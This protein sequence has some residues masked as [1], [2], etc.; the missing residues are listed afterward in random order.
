MH[1]T[2]KTAPPSSAL[3]RQRVAW[4][5]WVL[6]VLS[7]VG[8][9]FAVG[10]W[11]IGEYGYGLT[12]FLIVLG[13]AVMTRKLIQRV[14]DDLHGHFADQ[15]QSAQAGLIIALILAFFALPLIL[16]IWWYLFDRK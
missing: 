10:F 16:S 6:V 5:A 13:L 14:P 7:V 15:S 3:T 11:M 12:I 1:A 8:G 9:R 2:E 4:L